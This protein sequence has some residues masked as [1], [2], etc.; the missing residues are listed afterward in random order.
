MSI[1]LNLDLYSLTMG[2]AFFRRDENPRTSFELFF[3]SHPFSGGYSLYAGLNDALQRVSS[4]RY[5]AES[6]DYLDSLGLFDKSFLN[7]L[8]DFRFKGEILSQKEGN[9]IFPNTPLLQVNGDLIES[10]FLEALLLNTLNFQSLIATKAAR[11]RQVIPNKN[12]LD[13]GLRRAQGLDGA[14]SAS[15]A[16]Y[17]GGTD[18]TSYVNAAKKYSIKVSGTMA[19]AWVM[20]F[21]NEYEAFESYAKLFPSFPVFLIDTYDTL[22]SGIESAIKV[23]KRSI[24]AG[25]NFGIRID[26][27]DLQFLTQEAREKLDS[28]GCQKAQ[29]FVSNDLDEKIIAQLESTHSPIDGYG[30]GTQLITGGSQSSFNGVYKMVELDGAGVMKVSATPEKMSNPFRKRLLRFYN[31]EKRPLWDLQLRGG[32]SPDFTQKITCCHPNYSYIHSH[33]APHDYDHWEDLLHPVM[34]DG[35]VLTERPTLNAIKNHA[36]EMLENLPSKYKRFINPHTYKVSLSEE[37]MREKIQI[38]ENFSQ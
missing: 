2:Y 24:E 38:I 20:S 27:G 29:I 33:L 25:N 35:E 4:F 23:G 17:I 26:S 28:A 6:L 8:K 12:F 19:H 7:Y 22:G 15:R 30:V 3:R 1:G 9:V 21:S 16:A 10:L 37:L 11:I 34:Q 31:A 14:L 5:D 13:F 32:E 18:S 36:K